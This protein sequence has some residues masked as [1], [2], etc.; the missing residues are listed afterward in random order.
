MAAVLVCKFYR[1]EKVEV[2]VAKKKKKTLSL[3]PSLT[4]S[5]FQERKELSL[6][7]SLFSFKL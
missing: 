2:E 1:K 3:S 7:V 4:L 6:C 5:L